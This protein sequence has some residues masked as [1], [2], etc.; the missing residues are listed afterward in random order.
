MHRTIWSGAISFGLVTIPIHVV[1]A[2]E[3]HSIHFHQVHLDDV[4]RVRV[5]KYCELEDRGVTQGEIDK[6]YPLT[7][8]TIVPV[9]DEEPQ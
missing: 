6:G 2:T 9:L 7:K 1:S 5:Q 3:D 8:D 4:A